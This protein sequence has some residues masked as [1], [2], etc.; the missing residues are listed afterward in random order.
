MLIKVKSERGR[1]HAIELI[2][3]LMDKLG[4]ARIE[5]EAEDFR[6]PFEETDALIE[7]GL[8]KVS[9]TT[10]EAIGEDS[11]VVPTD[12]EDLLKDKRRSV[13]EELK[14]VIETLEATGEDEVVITAEDDAAAEALIDAIDVI[15]AAYSSDGH[16]R[17]VIVVSATGT[18]IV[19]RK[20]ES[21]EP[22]FTFTDANSDGRALV[23]PYTRAEY[24]ALP[25][26]KKKS[27]LTSIKALL[28]YSSTARLLA[29]LESLENR[30]ERINE[31]IEKLRARLSEK[32][33]SL[34]TSPVWEEAVKR[35]V[36]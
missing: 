32:R 13:E 5:R 15:E 10:G 9:S 1:N 3:I 27:V 14:E 18:P 24:L 29:A 35:V 6:L 4:I 8:I 11:K 20:T 36:K 19:R 31:R 23:I 17:R 26:K 7:R 28:A 12:V 16:R 33:K 21:D 30:G 34:P 2:S 25:R 22:D